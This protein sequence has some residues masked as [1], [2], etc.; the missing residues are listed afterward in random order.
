MHSLPLLGTSASRKSHF[1][2]LLR[3]PSGLVLGRWLPHVSHGLLTLLLTPA[4]LPLLFLICSSPPSAHCCLP[5]NPCF[6]PTPLLSP[7]HSPLI[8][9]FL[10]KTP[11]AKAVAW[12]LEQL[13]MLAQLL[14]LGT[15]VTL[16][17]AEEQHWK[18]AQAKFHYPTTLLIN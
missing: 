1:L 5:T 6:N 11:A 13:T 7:I 17:S 18:P 2:C 4:S 12:Q 9:P 8:P 10:A 16:G 3:A 14:V 15:R